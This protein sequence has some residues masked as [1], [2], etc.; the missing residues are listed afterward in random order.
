MSITIGGVG[1][2]AAA[3]GPLAISGGGT[4]QT[5][6][7][8]AINA[9]LP[10]QTGEDGKILGTNAGAALWIDTPATTPG[11]APNTIQFNNSGAFGG[12]PGLTFS[13]GVLTVPSITTTT[14]VSSPAVTTPTVTTTTLTGTA[15]SIATS[16]GTSVDFGSRYTELGSSVTATATTA[17]NCA[18]GNNF[19]VTMSASI[20]TLTF[21]A[22]PAAG[23]VYNLTLFLNQDATGGRTI[24]WPASVRWPGG[25]APTLS[26]A[27]KTDVI[28]LVTNNGG[29]TW[30]GFAAGLNF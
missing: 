11:G 1:V 26:A 2:S 12:D 10:P 15:G 21:S 23:R 4:G 6:A 19:V 29:T 20:T 13:G 24:I 5:T 27:N 22:I 18:L 7:D 16:V 3:S 30:L 17:L 9:L 28:T 8:A 14:A 25:T